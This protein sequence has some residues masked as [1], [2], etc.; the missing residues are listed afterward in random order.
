MY[1][2]MLLLAPALPMENDPALPRPGRDVVLRWNETALQ[3]IR[4][5]RTPPPLAARNLA[6]LHA[7]I[8]DA[9]N[10][11]QRTHRAYRVEA[12]VA[13]GTS[14]ETAAAVAAHRVLISLYPKQIERFDTVLDESLA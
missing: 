3:A 13:P 12:I 5:E 2:L 7:S 6:I 8:Y 11:V 4:A 14:T 10:A 9:V 1:S